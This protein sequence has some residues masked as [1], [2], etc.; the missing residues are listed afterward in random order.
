MQKSSRH[1]DRFALTTLSVAVALIFV[2][3]AFAGD[4]TMEGWRDYARGSITPSFEW[5]EQSK[6]E[7]PTLMGRALAMQS[8]LMS[9][10]LSESVAAPIELEF[11]S[12][13]SGDSPDRNGAFGALREVE[14]PSAGLVRN[15]LSAD[16]SRDLDNQSRISAGVVLANQQ[17]ASFGL[18]TEVLDQVGSAGRDLT[19]K[20]SGTGVRVGFERDLND[21]LSLGTSL[22]SKINMEAF[23][24]YR[25]LFADPGDFDLP[26]RA[27][28]TAR[29]RPVPFA[30]VS[31]SAQ[32]IFY[33]DLVAF[34]SRALPVRFLA[35]LNDGSQPKLTWR[36]LDVLS[37]DVGFAMGSSDRL[38][39]R[40]S[41]QQQPEPSSIVLL[42]AFS[43]ALTDNN[44]ALGFEH[45]FDRA[46]ALRFAASYAPTEYYLGNISGLSSNAGSGSQVEAEAFW[47][48]DF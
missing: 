32:R 33:S 10:H 36:D 12:S 46:G 31:V 4:A 30:D 5:V 25:G 15:L 38:T 48:F 17:F 1:A 18:G 28:V 34:S 26:A 2:E 29:W 16:I 40:Y 45:R 41:T 6:L 37:A 21:R 20:A 9:A 14:V 23:Q 43:S 47:R 22:Q 44:F 24:S 13:V 27:S 19:E 42:N 11:S 39:L 8:S 35:L 7:A 3:P